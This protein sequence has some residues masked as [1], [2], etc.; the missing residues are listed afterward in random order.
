LLGPPDDQGRQIEFSHVIELDLED[1][2]IK[3]RASGMK[4]DAEDG[5]VYSKWE[6]TERNKP[7]PV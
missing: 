3:L 1:D 5:I 7:K 6:I 4:L 2:E